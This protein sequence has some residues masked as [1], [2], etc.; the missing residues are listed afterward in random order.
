MFIARQLRG[1]ELNETRGYWKVLYKDNAKY[2]SRNDLTRIRSLVLHQQI[3]PKLLDYTKDFESSNERKDHPF[4]APV[5]IWVHQEDDS[6]SDSETIIK[7]EVLFWNGSS[8][9]QT[10]AFKIVKT[11]TGKTNYYQYFDAGLKNDEVKWLWY[12]NNNSKYVYY[13]LGSDVN[14]QLEASLQGNLIY[15][16]PINVHADK[17]DG[18][19]FNNCSLNILKREYI[20]K[21]VNE[22]GDADKHNHKTFVL[23]ATFNQ[24]ESENRF[25]HMVEQ[26]TV[27]DYAFPRTLQRRD[28]TLKGKGEVERNYGV[29]DYCYNVERN[30]N[31]RMKPLSSKLEK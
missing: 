30:Y 7:Y 18:Q 4:K 23:R 19:Y 8:L 29:E 26:V 24:N 12:D 25:I 5:K 3:A 17:D 20:K 6:D 27:T 31:L 21:I 9:N 14:E 10:H 1:V 15:N 22:G 2:A 16:Y 13:R 28:Q 11:D